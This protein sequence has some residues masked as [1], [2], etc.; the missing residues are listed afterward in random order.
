MYKN[1]CIV[2]YSFKDDNRN[3]SVKKSSGNMLT[4]ALLSLQFF[5]HGFIQMHFV[6]F[7][8]FCFSFMSKKHIKI[9]TSSCMVSS[10]ISDKFPSPLDEENVAP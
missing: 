5:I 2:W 4:H 9:S 3:L 6:F 8:F 10:A 1:Q 7:E